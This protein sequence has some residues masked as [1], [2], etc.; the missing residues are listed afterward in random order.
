MLDPRGW[1]RFKE[2]FLTTFGSEATKRAYC[3]DLNIFFYWMKQNRYNFKLNLLPGPSIIRDFTRFQIFSQRNFKKASKGLS[4]STIGRRLAAVRSF[5]NWLIETYQLGGKNPIKRV[6][7]YLGSKWIPQRLPIPVPE[8]IIGR[9]LQSV[10]DSRDRL[11]FR[12]YSDTGARLSEL[13]GLNEQ[14][15]KISRLPEDNE[16]Y[17]HSIIRGKGNKEREIYLSGENVKDILAYMKSKPVRMDNALFSNRRGR[18]LSNIAVEKRFSF[19]R[20]KSGLSHF[21]I[22]QLRHSFA[23]R[24]I[25]NG[26]NPEILRKLLGHSHMNTTFQYV[27]ISDETTR[28]SFL[29]VIKNGRK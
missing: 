9:F 5:I 25:K 16:V 10:A 7:N 13:L 27:Q 15:I 12:L 18:R 29:K 11:L 20:K 17:G 4:K 26:M 24:C 1:V 14:D 6:A 21:T 3:S 8:P 2:E 22:H 28:S 19:W 23:T